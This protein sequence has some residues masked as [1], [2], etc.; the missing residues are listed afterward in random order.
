MDRIDFAAVERM[1]DI[2]L[3]EDIG[4]GDITT[5][6]AVSAGGKGIGQ[7]SA[8]QPCVVA[9]LFLV[10]RIFKR[11]DPEVS[12]ECLVPDGR[13]VTTGTV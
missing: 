11:I 10:E 4:S 12:V 6:A 1:I 9:G 2:A 8:K 13:K 7:I 3:A 5:Q